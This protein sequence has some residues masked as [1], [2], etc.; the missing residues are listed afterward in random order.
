MLINF[1]QYI[2]IFLILLLVFH[3]HL[4]YVEFLQCIINTKH[5]FVN[6][7]KQI[8]LVNNLFY[9]IKFEFIIQIIIFG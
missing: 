8:F 1:I 4:K 3:F 5:I 2:I 6:I 7:R 9:L